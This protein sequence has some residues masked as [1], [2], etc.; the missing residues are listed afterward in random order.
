[1][2]QHVRAR[3]PSRR[4]RARDTVRLLAPDDPPRGVIAAALLHDVGKASSA[5]G[6]FS[7]VGVTLAAMAVGRRRLVDWAGSGG[8][9][10]GRLCAP[11]SANDL[12]HD[13]LGAELLEAAGSEVLTSTWAREHHLEPARWTVDARVGAALKA[14]DGD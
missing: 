12:A 2:A 6:T 14:A 7:R 13:R 4:G 11:G 3:P 5:L 10:S 9:R 1:M 8:S